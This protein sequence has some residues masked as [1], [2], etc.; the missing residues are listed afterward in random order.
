[1]SRPLTFSKFPRELT[2]RGW[3]VAGTLARHFRTIHPDHHRSESLSARAR[4]R[5]H[6]K[7]SSAGVSSRSAQEAWTLMHVAWKKFNPSYYPS[8][9]SFQLD[10]ALA[11]F[12]T[13]YIE[14]RRAVHHLGYQVSEA[15]ESTLEQGWEHFQKLQ[16]RFQKS[17]TPYPFRV[18]V[19]VCDRTVRTDPSPTQFTLNMGT[20][21]RGGSYAA[22]PSAAKSWSSSATTGSK[23]V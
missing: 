6:V 7:R 8:T 15:K 13:E 20:F 9:K 14:F 11:K 16:D 18:V 22:R 1:M 21:G 10:A 2:P 12:W 4:R 17:G 19:V 3:V 5:P 23:Q